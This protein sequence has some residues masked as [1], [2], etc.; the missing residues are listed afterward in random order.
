MSC[1]RNFL[2]FLCLSGWLFAVSAPGL[3]FAADVTSLSGDSDLDRETL[4]AAVAKARR[5]ANSEVEERR[6]AM[7]NALAIANA[8][9]KAHGA[10]TEALLIKAAIGTEL[11]LADEAALAGKALLE[12][13]K[14]STGAELEKIN[15]VL[16]AM[17][18]RGWLSPDF[19]ARVERRVA[20]LETARQSFK[21]GELEKAKKAM[22]EAWTSAME[23]DSS[24]RGLKIDI[25]YAYDNWLK[26][27]E[28]MEQFYG[29]WIYSEHFKPGA[30][31]QSGITLELTVT[32]ETKS[33]PGCTLKVSGNNSFLDRDL[34]A[35]CSLEIECPGE[36]RVSGT[37]IRQRRSASTGPDYNVSNKLVTRLEFSKVE[38]NYL[39]TELST[40]VRF[41]G[42]KEQIVT[43]VFHASS[44][45][46][47]SVE[48]L[49]GFFAM[50]GRAAGGDGDSNTAESEIID[51]CTDTNFDHLKFHR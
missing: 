50:L 41:A 3:V 47:S 30:G 39:G 35:T 7:M 51:R 48:G 12:K 13:R 26:K 25:D 32:S 2:R 29:T 38:F 4:Q 16:T 28:R 9:L 42:G 1:A 46:L 10:S 20:A 18:L 19:L 23:S 43:W 8:Y 34:K 36:A 11:D 49:N 17:N 24:L 22:D 44:G 40:V 21:A 14:T 27:K 31:G 6:S 33:V 45:E 5:I 15:T 37:K